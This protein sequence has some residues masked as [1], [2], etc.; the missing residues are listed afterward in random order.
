MNKFFNFNQLYQDKGGRHIYL[1]TKTN[2]AR[3]VPDKEFKKVNAFHQRIP[4]AIAVGAMV[5]Y[6]TNN[7]Y[8]GVGIGI[9]ALAVFEYMLRTKII[10]SL[11]PLRKYDIEAN[12]PIER[13]IS[14]RMMYMKVAVYLVAGGLLVYLGI[15][16]SKDQLS[17]I[18]VIGVGIFSIFLGIKSIFELMGKKR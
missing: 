2:T 4:I 11:N 10:P 5:G 6:L 14:D 9:I 7:P 15:V 16:D 18:L 1:E 17:Q 8:Y 13:E 3:L 12:K